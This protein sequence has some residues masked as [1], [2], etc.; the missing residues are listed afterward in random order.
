MA[1]KSIP[2]KS[3]R[4]RRDYMWM[5]KLNTANEDVQTFFEESVA[6][7]LN[8]SRLMAGGLMSAMNSTSIFASISPRH[9]K[10]HPEVLIM[11]ETWHNGLDLLRGDE[12]DSIMNYRLRD[13]IIDYL[14]KKSIS[15]NTFIER[16]ETI[17]F[18]YPKQV[19]HILYNLIDSHDTPRFLT[20]AGNDKS[21]LFL[22]IVMQ[23]LLPGMPV[24]YYGDE[25]G[26]GG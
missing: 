20:V 25:I 21:L 15:L 2:K 11:A 10:H 26:Y 16:I 18:D 24:I 5:P 23:L 14:V 22:A 9:Q 3:L 8:A 12:V 4:V 1:I 6:I 13:A 7:G 19:H 17:C